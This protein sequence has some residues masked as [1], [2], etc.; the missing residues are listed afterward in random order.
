MSPPLVS[1]IMPCR[2]ERASIEGAL[3]SILDQ[4]APAG[5]FEIIVADGMS[6]DGTREV[7]E[8]MAG[9]NPGIRVIDNPG[10]IVSSGLNAAIGAARGQILV[11]L[12]AH[13]TYAR[14]YVCRCVEVLRET[15]ADNVGGPWVARGETYI[16]SAIAA[17]FQSPFAVGW[18]RG[19]DPTYEGP[20]DSVYLGCWRRAVFDRIG[21]FDEALVRNQDDEWNLRLTRAGGRIWQSPRIQSRYGARESLGALL[22]QYLQY[23]YWKV[24]V[25]R[26]H[27][28]PASWR[29]LVPG[30]FLI[31]L[32]A[33]A[34][35]ALFWPPA[36]SFALVLMGLYVLAL[37]AASILCASRGGWRLL[38]VLPLVFACYHLGYGL[39]FLAGLGF[40]PRVGREGRFTRLTRGTASP[41]PSR[42]E[43]ISG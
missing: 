21:L 2:N 29:H 43:K 24:A 26:K 7:L 22:R 16:G 17:A 1:L 19:H 31:A 13:T 10:R 41:A 6:D 34:A 9:E 32:I 33:L 35:A 18:A 37:L 14:D 4:E 25:I 8:R 3:R 11:R 27:R 36:G 40:R 39:G 38:P 30:G 42:E 20:V 23:G 15:G 5:D 12:D 28:I